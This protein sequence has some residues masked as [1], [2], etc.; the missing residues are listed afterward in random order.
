MLSS[1]ADFICNILSFIIYY[2]VDI[3]NIQY[4]IDTGIQVSNI[5]LPQE[6]TAQLR[7]YM[8][9]CWNET[10]SSVKSSFVSESSPLS[11]R[12]A[13]FKSPCKRDNLSVNNVPVKQ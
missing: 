8:V 3:S 13:A 11:S 1:K 6:S 10:S 5:K 9:A 4:R 12:N 2:V 7:V